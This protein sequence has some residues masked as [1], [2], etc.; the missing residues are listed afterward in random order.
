MP[1]GIILF[2]S[3]V[4]GGI[5]SAF[6]SNSAGAIK[7]ACDNWSQSEEQY[8]KTLK[9]W[10]DIIKDQSLLLTEAKQLGQDL[11]LSSITYK[12]S[13]KNLKDKYRKQEASYI[14]GLAIFIFIILLALLFK[15]F[16]VIPSIWKYIT[17]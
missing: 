13:L 4:A 12:N 14:I 16:N 3:M 5:G 11:V 2:G 8:K 6:N 1:A 17:K 9:K 15:Y 10:Q 7:N